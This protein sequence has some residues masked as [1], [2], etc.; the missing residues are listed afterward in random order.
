VEDPSL[1]RRLINPLTSKAG[2]PVNDL[3]EL[4]R[5]KNSCKIFLNLLSPLNKSY[6]NQK[7]L[8]YLISQEKSTN[9]TKEDIKVETKSLSKKLLHV[10]R[11]QILKHLL[12]PLLNAI[13][14]NMDE[15]IRCPIAS[16]IVF[17]TIL[18][19]SRQLHPLS[20]KKE[21]KAKEQQVASKGKKNQKSGSTTLVTL[22]PTKIDIQTEILLNS[23]KSIS[24]AI[25]RL[26]AEPLDLSSKTK[27]FPKNKKQ[28]KKDAKKRKLENPGDNKEEEEDKD[29]NKEKDKKENKIEKTN[30][31]EDLV[32]HFILKRLLLHLQPINANELAIGILKTLDKNN[33]LTIAAQI[34]RPAFVMA[35]ALE[36]LHKNL[37]SPDLKA[38]TTKNQQILTSSSKIKDVLVSA[39]SSPGSKVLEKLLTTLQ[40]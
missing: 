2:K 33:T 3:S 32:G 25:E 13:S 23:W 5:D 21:D 36:V 16:N 38:N 26:I 9:D 11:S 31:I 28:L 1:A 7:D 22:T 37:S 12:V 30:I 19:T 27:K 24:K 17:E 4:L 8:V 29:Q 39:K 18:E 34:N 15:L 6:L 40:L 35:T 10:R 20:E 14:E